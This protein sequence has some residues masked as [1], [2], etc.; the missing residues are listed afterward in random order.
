MPSAA[1]DADEV[2]DHSQLDTLRRLG[3]DGTLLAGVA[4]TF[5]E[6]V[7]LRL[8]ELRD[9]VHR[10]DPTAVARIAHTV[11]GSAATLG[12]RRA[13]A[14]S[15]A[16]EAAAHAGDPGEVADRLSLLEAELESATRALQ[17]ARSEA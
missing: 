3:D 10:Q 11:K 2:L 4:T 14:A 9:A 17:S 5:A 16:V 12:A 7:P 13:A 15:A 8:A 1:D 6:Q